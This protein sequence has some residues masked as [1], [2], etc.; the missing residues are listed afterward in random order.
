MGWLNA[1]ELTAHKMAGRVLDAD[2]PVEKPDAKIM[3]GAIKAAQ[4]A[5][6]LALAAALTEEMADGCDKPGDA[7]SEPPPP[8]EPPAPA[9]DA[10]AGV[11]ANEPAPSGDAP[12]A[13]AP[14]PADELIE[15]IARLTA[16]R[17]AAIADAA[18]ARAAT[19]TAQDGIRN[20][21][22]KHDK[23]IA[24]TKALRTEHDALRA[25]WDRLTG[26]A[27]AATVSTDQT[28]ASG[29]NASA[30]KRPNIGIWPK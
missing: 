24:E 17:D 1:D 28:T 20:L 25:Q 21:Q 26:A 14:D 5:G 4:N 29:A 13:P 11:G 12:N 9:A 23:L 6:K 22:S 15:R 3:E 27:R 19:A 7:A 16:E 8:V 10:G 2:A 18:T 30:A